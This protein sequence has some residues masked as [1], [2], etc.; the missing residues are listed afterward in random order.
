MPTTTIFT[1][2]NTKIPGLLVFDI[3]NPSDERGWF[4][5]KFQREKLIAAGMPA[6]FVVV[7]NSLSYNKD[8]GVVRGIHAEPWDKYISL[9][10]GR[11]F[12]AYVDLRKG[13]NF[14]V[15]ETF[16]LTP[17]RAVFLPQGVGNSFQTLEPDTYY[18]YS[19]NKHWSADNLNEYTFVNLADPTLA[20]QWP[21]PL[22]DSIMSEKDQNHPLLQ[23]I[24]PM[25][26]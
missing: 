11:V 6:D 17:N 8:R 3:E 23:D 2:I 4:Q 22:A 5:E 13:D 10:K 1:A 25:E 24:Q 20:I 26:V 7:Q 14:G 12:V 21:I 15:T 9:V 18:L 19:I 16:E